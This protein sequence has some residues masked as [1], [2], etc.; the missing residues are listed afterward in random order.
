M[1]VALVYDR[2]NKMGGAERIL[3]ALH[4]LF[5]DAPLYTAVYDPLGAPWAKDF[6]VRP[7]FMN[8][9]PLAKR[10]HE[11]FP[12]LTPFA[13]E[14]F[15]FDGFDLVISI[16]S[17]EAKSIITKPKTTHI[18]YCL[19]PTRYLWSGY[20]LYTH[21]YMHG[22]SIPSLFLRL[23]A[24]MLRK[25]D[26]VASSRPDSYVAI[27]NRIKKRIA[28]YYKQPVGAVIYPP[29]ATDVFHPAKHNKK[30]DYYLFVS[31]LV[32]YKRPDIVIEACSS[33]GVP[34]IVI[35]DGNERARLM[36]KA[37]PGTQFITGYLTDEK[38]AQY[39]QNCRAFLFAGDEDFG[40]VAAE[41]QSSGKPVIA[42][43]QSGVAE[44]VIDGKTGILFDKQTP[45]A[46]VAAIQ[47][48][49]NLTFDAYACRKN[50]ERFGAA[51]FKKEMTAYIHSFMNRV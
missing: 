18:C 20:D 15:D 16:T 12:W 42:Y 24:P 10:H 35:G 4:D 2:I 30:G 22:T 41:A 21:N 51:R 39:Y 50:A 28:A 26:M 45:E 3:L 17:A 33:L 47:K 40:I 8:R 23:F 6:D 36:R 13:F 29:V 9:I 7:S 37:G 46:L 19:T 44:I 14:S 11:L 1:N 25:W 38:L 5:P 32:G 34:L 48:S 27:S 31:R 43:R 49:E